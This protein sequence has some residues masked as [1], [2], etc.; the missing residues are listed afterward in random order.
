MSQLKSVFTDLNEAGKI[1]TIYSSIIMHKGNSLHV[2]E[3]VLYV[4]NSW[5]KVTGD[6]YVYSL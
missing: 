4:K 6:L 3:T 2:Q 5:Q 1:R